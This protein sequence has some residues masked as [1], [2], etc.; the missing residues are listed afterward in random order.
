MG[1]DV[2]G[3]PVN[4]LANANILSL[5]YATFSNLLFVAGWILIWS[6][7]SQG[8]QSRQQDARI[9]L[10]S[11]LWK[12]RS[13]VQRAV[14]GLYSNLPTTLTSLQALA[15]IVTVAAGL[16]LLRGLF[17]PVHKVIEDENGDHPWVLPSRTT[18]SRMFPKRHSFSY[19]YLQVFIPVTFSGYC[20]S[21][22]SVGK[23]R[24]KGWFHVDASDYLER[25]TIQL[26][27]K[28]K[29]AAYLQSQVNVT[30]SPFLSYQLTNYRVLIT[31]SGNMHIS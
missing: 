2:S 8:D 11:L 12:W 15:A 5:D 25:S 28:A 31:P 7:R 19:S 29:L 13:V 22:I 4:P 23:T 14:S 26:S 21:L 3:L 20:G 24:Q 16:K 27:L 1:W 6:L 30:C 18:H 10:G 9:F 17:L